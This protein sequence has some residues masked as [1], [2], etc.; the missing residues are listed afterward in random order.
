MAGLR[1]PVRMQYLEV[2]QLAASDDLRPPGAS[3]RPSWPRLVAVRNDSF[4]EH[5]TPVA[6]PG[7]GYDVD[8]GGAVRAALC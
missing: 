7:S 3:G 1:R 6:A 2:L 8:G 4:D 5:T